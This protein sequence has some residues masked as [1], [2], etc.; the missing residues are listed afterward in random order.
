MV[1]G[2]FS[3]HTYNYKPKL[4]GDG[5]HLWTAL[6]NFGCYSFSLHN[7]Q[8]NYEFSVDVY[9]FLVEL[10][11]T[12]YCK[13]LRSNSVNYTQ[14]G[15]DVMNYINENVEI[16]GFKQSFH[17]G[18]LSFLDGVVLSFAKEMGLIDGDQ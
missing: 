12:G 10:P 2:F 14:P 15:V 18:I 7:N 6:S 13:L 8:N 1:T 17:K 5:V 3:E 16:G 11:P 4:G 9:P